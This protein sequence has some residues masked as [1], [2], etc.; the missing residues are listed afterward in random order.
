MCEKKK[1][2]VSKEN[3]KQEEV[4]IEE[5]LIDGENPGFTCAGSFASAGSASCP[6]SSASTGST[7]SS[8]GSD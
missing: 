8:A 7:F 2:V 3:I 1:E 5:Q 6:A 4:Y